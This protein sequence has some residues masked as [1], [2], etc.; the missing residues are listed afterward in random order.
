MYYKYLISFRTLIIKEVRRFMG[1]WLET[2]LLPIITNSLFFIVFGNLMGSRIGAMDGTSYVKFI[3]PGLIMM[4][5][6]TSSYAN[7]AFSF[8]TSKFFRSIEDILIS[9]I[10]NWL[11]LTAYLMGGVIRGLVVALAVTLTALFFS[12]LSVH[13]LG[14][15]IVVIILTSALFSLAGL[16]NGV[17]AKK[18]DDMGIVPTFV[19]TPLTYLGGVFFSVQMLPPIWKTIALFN[20]IL[21]CINLFRYSML[22]I[23]DVNVIWAFVGLTVLVALVFLYCLRLINKGVG[24][25]T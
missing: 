15:M 18:F 20:P 3:A 22:G 10:P 21:Y 16:I 7:V 25:K 1:F 12:G 17:F 13:H 2:L 24:I 5:V 6:I 9:P 11:V 4:S 14:L 8:F 19:L 23:S